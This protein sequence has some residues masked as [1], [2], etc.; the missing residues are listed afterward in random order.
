MFMTFAL[1]CIYNRIG[2]FAIATTK[3]QCTSGGSICV[4]SDMLFTP[5]GQQKPVSLQPR[6]PLKADLHLDTGGTG[7]SL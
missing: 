1:E 5:F 2:A 4:I 6:K 7:K 3:L